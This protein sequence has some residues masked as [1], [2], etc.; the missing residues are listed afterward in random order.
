MYVAFEES[1]G[2]HPQDD[3]FLDHELWDFANTPEEHYPLLLFYH[4]LV[5]YRRQVLKQPD[6]VFAMFLLGEDFTEEQRRRNFDYYDPLTTGDS[7]LSARIQSIVAAELGYR[8]K[9][10]EYWKY[11][12]LM[13]LANVGGNVK[14]G[15]HIA[16]WGGSWMAA[17]YGFAGMRDRGGRLSFDP[18]GYLEWL[19]FALTVRGR[20][21]EVCIENGT[22]TYLVQGKAGL[23]IE[24]CGE[25]LALREGEPVT[26]HIEKV[27]GTEI[28]THDPDKAGMARSVPTEEGQHSG[29]PETRP[30]TERSA[31]PEEETR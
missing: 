12:L 1:L 29:I 24:H 9:A 15:C 22:V 31:S 25:S 21:L 4:P 11:A 19:R 7:S 18:R 30:A 3:E 28:E 23:T 27:I 10:L 8:T 20:R 13:D 2:I 14:D 6:V 26:R 16:S 5:I 17:V